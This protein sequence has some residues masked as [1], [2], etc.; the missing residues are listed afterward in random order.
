MEMT[1]K[2]TDLNESSLDSRM[3]DK[4]AESTIEESFHEEKTETNESETKN[5]A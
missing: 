3:S 2:D 4:Q 5:G 1:K